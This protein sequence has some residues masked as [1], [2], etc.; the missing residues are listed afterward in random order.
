MTAL[1][2]I[3]LAKSYRAGTPGCFA[4]AT[5]LRHASLTVWPGEIVAVE[6]NRGS[7][8]STLLRCAAGLLKPDAGSV[9]WQDSRAAS[10]GRVA[11]VGAEQEHPAESRGR[12]ARGVDLY[13]RVEQAIVHEHGVL[14]VDDL[15][16]VGALECRMVMWMLRRRA[17]SG[18]A[19]LVAADDAIAGASAVSRVVTLE[20]GTLVQRRKRSAARIAASSCDSRARASARSTYGRS[21]RSPQ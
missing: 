1:S 6:G 9:L 14:L 3:A 7:G 5:V 4:T 12:L 8:R 10:G 13:T 21:L 17:A 20:D 15:P 18:I 16:S 19:I 11:Y 2:I